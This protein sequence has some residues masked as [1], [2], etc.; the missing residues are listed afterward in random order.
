MEVSASVAPTLASISA[1]P[2]MTN[3]CVPSTVLSNVIVPLPVLLLIVMSLVDKFTVPSKVISP[4][5]FVTFD[6]MVA[7]SLMIKLPTLILLK[8]IE[9]PILP[10]MVSVLLPSPVMALPSIC[11]AVIVTVPAML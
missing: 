9:S 4:P 11:A 10:L 6:S 1:F 7:L 3:A 8:S 5:L 2:V